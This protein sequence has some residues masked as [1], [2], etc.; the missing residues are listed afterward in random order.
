MTK[1]VIIDD[2]EALRDGLAVLLGQSGLEV[3]AAAG[4]V[5]SGEDVV[6][7]S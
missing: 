1:L 7:K 4:N 5:A 2:H 6:A 3:V